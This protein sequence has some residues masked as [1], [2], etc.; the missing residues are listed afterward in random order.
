MQR[1]KVYFQKIFAVLGEKD[2]V[3]LG[4]SINLCQDRL[5]PF[6]P[7]I[8]CPSVVKRDVSKHPLRMCVCVC[9]LT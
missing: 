1:G 2:G 9:V 7:D 8:P 6:H 4:Q 5:P 3:D